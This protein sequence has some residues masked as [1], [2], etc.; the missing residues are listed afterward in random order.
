MFRK[1]STKRIIALL[2]S[3]V[4]LFVALFSQNLHN[5]GSGEVFK[6]FHFQKTEKTFTQSPCIS[7]FT[8]CLSCHI[9]HEGKSLVP[10]EFSFSFVEFSI[11]KEQVFA[12]QQRFAK[13]Q[14]VYFQLRGPPADFI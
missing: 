8:D 9:F 4:Y 1:N 12:Y 2:F 5:H 14:P 10:Q 11:F 3:A 13:L 6:D 7:S